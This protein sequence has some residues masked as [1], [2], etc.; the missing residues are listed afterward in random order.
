MNFGEEDHGGK[1]PFS[2]HH[3]NDK[4]CQHYLTTVHNDP[5]C[6]VEVGF[7]RFSTV[8]SLIPTTLSR[9]SSLEGNHKVQPI[10]QE[11]VVTCMPPGVNILYFSECFSFGN[12]ELSSL[13]S[14]PFF[15]LLSLWV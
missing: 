12:G 15:I 7:V 8:K 11:A 2:S 3:I 13:A 14:W 4:C 9:L 6:L 1:V 10:V 5:D